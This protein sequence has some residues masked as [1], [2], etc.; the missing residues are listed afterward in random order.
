MDSLVKAGHMEWQGSLRATY[1]EYLHPD[2]LDYE[3]YEM[4]EK[5]SDAS[6]PDLFQFST[7][8]GLQAAQRIKP[9]SLIEMSTANSIMRLMVTEEGAEQPIDTY[10]RFKNDINEWY[11]LMREDYHL[12]EDEIKVMEKYLLHLYGVGDTQEVVMQISMDEK[13]CGFDVAQ[14]NQLR[15]AIA[16]KDKDL[17][18]EMKEYMFSHGQE[19]GTSMNLLNYVWNE[20]IGKQLGL[21]KNWAQVKL[22]KRM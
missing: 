1:N 11:K 14:S 7:A 3:S 18:A 4:W 20:V 15:R 22:G 12:T 6:I 13:A 2:V 5:V 21:D 9:H 19:L 8:V 10:I 16:K 17:Q